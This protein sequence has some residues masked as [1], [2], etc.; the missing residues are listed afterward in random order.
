MEDIQHNVMANHRFAL[1]ADTTVFRLFPLT[2]SNTYITVVHVHAH[3]NTHTHT[4]THT[5]S[6]W[7][8]YDGTSIDSDHTAHERIRTYRL[9]DGVDH[10]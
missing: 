3:Q 8:L 7:L 2:S 9:T 1:R 6:W 10:Q 5:W 4:H